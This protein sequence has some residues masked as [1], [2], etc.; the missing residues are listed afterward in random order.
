MTTKN[1]QDVVARINGYR[2]IEKDETIKVYK[3][4]I[5]LPLSEL[6]QLVKEVEAGER[7]KFR[8]ILV[9]L[10][11]KKQSELHGGYDDADFL[12]AYCFSLQEA[13][14]RLQALT[15]PTSDIIEK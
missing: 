9:D 10:H 2:A 1:I 7:E 5:V 13:M 14:Q 11:N 8:Q 12:T 3:G 6:T 4:E 15:P